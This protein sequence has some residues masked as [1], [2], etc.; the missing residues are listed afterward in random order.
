M[1]FKTLSNKEVSI[2]IKPSDY[3]IRSLDDCRSKGQFKL[4]QLL[5]EFYGSHAIILEDFILPETKLSLDFFL[6]HYKL[7]FE[8]Q[9]IQHFQFSKFF[10]GDITGY[11]KQKK[12]DANKRHWCELNEIVLFEIQEKDLELGR[13]K[14]LIYG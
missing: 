8:M 5:Q 13:L 1:K 11:I 14:L 10:H 6:P 3:P 4:G 7:A 2:E 9:G 12:R